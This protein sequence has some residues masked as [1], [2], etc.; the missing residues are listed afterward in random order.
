MYLCMPGIMAADRDQIRQYLPVTLP[1][2]A[3][4]MKSIP[5]LIAGFF[6]VVTGGS[7]CSKKESGREADI[8]KFSKESGRAAND[9]EQGAEKGNVNAPP[10]A[11]VN[12]GPVPVRRI[13]YTAAV[14]LVTE[15]FARAETE[16]KKLVKNA[17][18]YIANSDIKAA[19]GSVRVGFW[20]ARIPVK[21]FDSFRDALLKLGEVEKNATDSEDLTEEFYDLENYIKNRK[22]EEEALRKL[23]E[24]AADKMDSFFAVRRELNQVREDLDRKQGRLKLLAN[25]TDMTTVSI[26]I[27]EIQ[28]YAPDKAPALVENPGFGVRFAQSLSDSAGSVVAFFQAVAILLAALLPWSPFI[29]AAAMPTW[30]CIKRKKHSPAPAAVKVQSPS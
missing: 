15:D 21:E 18:G 6:F 9:A 30:I 17:L 3:S 26:S 23:M 29:L 19:P 10:Q 7:G 11:N 8:K 4:G 20:K 14:Q 5:L 25:L 28:K 22:A 2:G 13:K 12:Q 24:R 16:V 1:S 27:R